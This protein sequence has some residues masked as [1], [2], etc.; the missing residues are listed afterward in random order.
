MTLLLLKK[1]LF[2]P[3]FRKSVKMFKVS[4]PIYAFYAFGLLSDAGALP[5]LKKGASLGEVMRTHGLRNKKMLE[6]MLDFLVGQ[7]VLT[8]RGG[9][10]FF[11]RL[12]PEINEK[13]YAFLETHFPA[14][15][16][17]V[18][19]LR[20]HAPRVLKT[21]KTIAYTGFSRR[22]LLDLWDAIMREAP[23]PLR[24]YAIEKFVHSVPEDARILDYGCGSGIGLE[25]IL[26]KSGKKVF[27]TGSDPSSKYLVLA[28]KNLR[29]L[30]LTTKSGLVRENILRTKLINSAS[31]PA[32]KTYDIV[33]MSLVLNHVTAK[34]RIGLFKK[35][36]RAL[37]K[38]GRIVIF[39]ITHASKHDRSPIFLMHVIPSHKDYP[40]RDELARDMHS[41][42]GNASVKLNGSVF[43]AEK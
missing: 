3:E 38:G 35:V 1:M 2:D 5:L 20:R 4:A 25:S 9:K 23:L 10:Y 31:L 22:K 14:S 30:Y 7:K 17:W 34:K 26:K 42:F 40:F 6:H 43:I 29:K 12:P 39:Q 11:S 13:N 18:E 32:R 41:V 36:F 28:R 19:E 16:E 37:N 15:V 8:F 24:E 27:L 21:G 33:F